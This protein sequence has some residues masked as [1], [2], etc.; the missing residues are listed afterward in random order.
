MNDLVRA[1]FRELAAREP[2]Y[3]GRPAGLSNIYRAE[4]L[5]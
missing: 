3:C 2:S 5:L 4:A 1:L